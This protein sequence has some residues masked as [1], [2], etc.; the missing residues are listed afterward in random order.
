MHYYDPHA[1]YTKPPTGPIFGDR[2]ADIYDSELAYTDAEIRRFV[3]GL[4]QILKPEDTILIVTGD[5]GE[6]F[7]EA[8]PNR[9]HGY[10]LHSE[11]LRLPLLIRTPFSRPGQVDMPVTPMDL[12]PTLVN[13]MRIPGSFAFEGNSLLPQLTGMP[14]DDKRMVFHQFYLSENVYHKKRTLQHVAIR[15]SSL[16]LIHDLTNNTLQLYRYHVDPLEVTNRIGDMPDATAI[17]KS[18]LSR[19]MARVAR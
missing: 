13:L 5:H 14:A 1:P 8:H 15:T 9:H 19:W 2:E 3:T 11:V 17:L 10:D 4:W 12:L 7:D 16:Y 18:E 6:A